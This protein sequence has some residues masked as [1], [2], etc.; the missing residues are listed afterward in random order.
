VKVRR[1]VQRH[2]PDRGKQGDHQTAVSR[3]ITDRKK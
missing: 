1:K 2:T 3:Q